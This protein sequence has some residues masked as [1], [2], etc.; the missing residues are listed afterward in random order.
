[1]LDG[2]KKISFIS[3]LIK[4]ALIF[5]IILTQDFISDRFLE[6]YIIIFSS[7]AVIST[8]VTIYFTKSEPQINIT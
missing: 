3:D 7:Y 2:K 8:L 6:P 1:M 5:Y 4:L